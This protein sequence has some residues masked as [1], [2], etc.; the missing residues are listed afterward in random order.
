[1]TSQN[2]IVASAVVFFAA[3]APAD[4]PVVTG[5][6]REASELILPPGFEA[7]VVFEGTG[8]SR[9]IYIRED[10]DIF[11]SL[12]GLRDAP[13]IFYLSARRIPFG[14]GAVSEGSDKARSR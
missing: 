7:M 3:C 2:R 11:V 8:E 1:M 13:H 14:S 12:A 4:G 6:E 5:D 9:E 10:G